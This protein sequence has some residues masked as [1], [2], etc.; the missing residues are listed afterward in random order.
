MSGINA[1]YDLGGGTFDVSIVRIIGNDVEVLSTEGV[2]QLG[3]DDFDRKLQEI[4]ARKHATATGGRLE[5]DEFTRNDA[6][7]LKKS[8]SQRESVLIR[9]AGKNGRVNIEVTRS[10]FEEAISSLI[11]Q[12]EMLCETAIDEAG[13]SAQEIDAVILAGGST[14]VPAVRAS[15]ARAFGKQPVAFANPDEVV[16]LGAALYAAYRTDKGNLNAVQRHAVS[17]IKIGEITSKYYGTLAVSFNAARQGQEMQNSII[18]KKGEKIP[19]SVTEKFFTLHDDQTAVDC[20][21][22]ES[23]TPETDPKFVRV[24][25]NGELPLPA[26]RERGQEI[27]VTFSYDANQTMHCSFVDVASG[28]KTD[29]DLRMGH[30]SENSDIDI[31]RFIVE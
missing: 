5:A 29:V 7:E 11:A 6:E 31:S 1:V 21:V 3:G 30:T 22:T 14:R 16:T 12:A 15:V 25:Y 18:I 20:S 17:K 26:G 23:S 4:V 19:A 8:L 9:P 27:Q 13:I 24:I 28:K 2:S 10:E